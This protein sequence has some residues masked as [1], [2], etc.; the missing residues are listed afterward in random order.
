MITFTNCGLFSY[1]VELRIKT[2]LLDDEGV[3]THHGL[4]HTVSRQSLYEDCLELYKKNLPTLIQEYPF[5]IKFE[6]EK[7]VDTGGVS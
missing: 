1:A 7:A 5:R 2:F 6:N 4:P 3:D